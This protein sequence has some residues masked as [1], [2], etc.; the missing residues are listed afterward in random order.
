MCNVTSQTRG[1]GYLS[2]FTIAKKAK[3]NLLTI[4]GHYCNH[5]S[6]LS[7]NLGNLRFSFKKIKKTYLF[8][9]KVKT[10]LRIVWTQ[11]TKIVASCRTICPASAKLTI[12]EISVTVCCV[13]TKL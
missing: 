11:N 6:S 12:L 4:V 10:L 2:K 8:L 1:F 9:G 13:H 5:T 3:R 7:G